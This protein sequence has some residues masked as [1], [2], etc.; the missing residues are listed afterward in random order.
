MISDQSKEDQRQI[1]NK[2]ENNQMDGARDGE[3]NVQPDGL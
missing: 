1:N 3:T 2:S